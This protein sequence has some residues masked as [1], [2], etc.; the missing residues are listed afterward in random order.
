MHHGKESG[1]RG[2]LHEI[3][4]ETLIMTCSATATTQG[5]TTTSNGIN[6][7]LLVELNA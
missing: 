4:S 2:K 7:W 6:G 1:D 5:L 3:D